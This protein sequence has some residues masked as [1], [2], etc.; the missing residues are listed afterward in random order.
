MA[1]KQD[2][3]K[4]TLETMDG[5]YLTDLEFTANDASIM[6]QYAM[7]RAKAE[8]IDL[9]YTLPLSENDI[10][11]LI[12]FSLESMIKDEALKDKQK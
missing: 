1:K 12:K 6:I 10:I 9:G 11:K 3:L 7:A 2:T 8:N 5:E 4:V